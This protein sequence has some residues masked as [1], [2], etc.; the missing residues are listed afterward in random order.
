MAI[1][2]QQSY[3][4]LDAFYYK[5]QHFIDYSFYLMFFFCPFS[6]QRLFSIQGY[7]YFVTSD[8]KCPF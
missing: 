2:L 4:V 7:H 3:K 1:P 8:D 6:Y 5:R